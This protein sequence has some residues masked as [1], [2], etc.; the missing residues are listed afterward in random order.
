MSFSGQSFFVLRTLWE[1][2][3]KKAESLLKG[4]LIDFIG[5]DLHHP[6]QLAMLTDR[7]VRKAA[8]KMNVKNDMFN[9][10]MK[11]QHHENN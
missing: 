9:E 2:H 3:P 4:S 8:G 1:K 11:T 6:A 5:T 7:S 10:P